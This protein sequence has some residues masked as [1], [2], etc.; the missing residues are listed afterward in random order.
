MEICYAESE[1]F[2]IVCRAG[3]PQAPFFLAG[4][5]KP[6]FS[7]TTGIFETSIW[8]L[9]FALIFHSNERVFG[10]ERFGQNIRNTKMENDGRNLHKL[11]AGQPPSGKGPNEFKTFLMNR[12]DLLAI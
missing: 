1:V 8:S 10:V 12:V 6:K 4:Q 11:G 2:T 5:K 9:S 7:C 3:D